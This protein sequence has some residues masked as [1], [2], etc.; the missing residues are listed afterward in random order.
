MRAVRHGFSI[1]KHSTVWQGKVSKNNPAG[2]VI[3]D[4]TGEVIGDLTGRV[5]GN[6]TGGVTNDLTGGVTL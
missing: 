6:L 3:G 4:L 2:K 5:T 1:D